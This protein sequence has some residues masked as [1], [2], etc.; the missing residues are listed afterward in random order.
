MSYKDSWI[1]WEGKDVDITVDLGDL[2]EIKSIDTDFLHQ[3]GAWILQ[4]KSVTYLLSDDGVN[5]RAQPKHELTDDQDGK[6]KFVNV[7]ETFTTPQK[8]RYVKV[9]VEGM[10]QCP[11]WHYGVG[12]PCWF[13]LDEITILIKW[14]KDRAMPG[15]FFYEWES[16]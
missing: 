3:I 9:A 5:W 12:N 15:A 1:G 7:V 14:K 10:K 6:V 4:P 13:F 8:A 11:G 2:T 16:Y